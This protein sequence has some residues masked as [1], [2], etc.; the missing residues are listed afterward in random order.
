MVVRRWPAKILA[1]AREI[2]R[3]AEALLRMT[4]FKWVN[5][6]SGRPTN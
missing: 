6:R 2:L 4:S 5:H 3:R 1:T